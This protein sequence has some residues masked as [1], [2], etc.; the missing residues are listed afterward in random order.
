MKQ[1]YNIMIRKLKSRTKLEFESRFCYLLIC[2]M[3]DQFINLLISSK[4]I[5][6]I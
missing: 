3:E 6:F 1:H 2:A 4:F 5:F